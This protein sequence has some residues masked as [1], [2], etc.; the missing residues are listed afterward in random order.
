[1]K[2]PARALNSFFGFELLFVFDGL[3]ISVFLK[4][5]LIDDFFVGAWFNGQVF[6]CGFVGEFEDYPF[7]Y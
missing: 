1:M 4:C 6:D 7:S 3:I 5:V 2:L